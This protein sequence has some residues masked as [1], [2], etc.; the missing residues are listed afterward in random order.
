[1]LLPLK[2]VPMKAFFRRVVVVAILPLLVARFVSP[3]STLVSLGRQSPYSSHGTRTTTTASTVQTPTTTSTCTTALRQQRLTVELDRTLNDEKIRGLF[4]WIARAYAGDYEY[5]N[6][7]LAIVAI[8]GNLPPQTEPVQLAERALKLLPKNAEEVPFGE[9]FSLRE[10]EMHSLGAMGAAQWSGRFKTRPH[11][12]LQIQNLTHV[13]D[14]VKGLPRGCR[15]TLKRAVALAEGGNFTVQTLPIYGDRP[16]PHSCLAHFRCVVEHEVR[17][18]A[19]ENDG[20][21]ASDFFSALG[22]AVGRYMGTTRMAGEIREYRNATTGRVIALAHEGKSDDDPKKRWLIGWLFLLVQIVLLTCC[23]PVLIVTVR[24]GR[25]VRGQ[26]FYATDD[27]AKNYV[28]FHSVHDL[29]RRSIE[30]TGVDVVDLGPSGSD[31]F[32]ELKERYG[33]VSVDDWVSYFLEHI[34]D[35]RPFQALT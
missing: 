8:F 22:E 14:W 18:L 1:M 10:R 21:D 5:N 28:W 33:F 30:A 26:W 9:P 29:V 6:L 31:A 2:I 15:R 16:A 25:T 20:A 35:L 4:A 17:L 23:I 3:F 27:A 24:K 34:N 7:M 12:L 11:A 13:D 19:N 32:S